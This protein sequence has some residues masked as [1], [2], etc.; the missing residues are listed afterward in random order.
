M[1][2]ITLSLAVVGIVALVNILVN[3]IKKYLWIKKY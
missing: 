1:E 3:F 2:L